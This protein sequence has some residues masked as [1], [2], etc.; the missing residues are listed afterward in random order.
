M[1]QSKKLT[2]GALLT[3]IYIVLLIMAVF[4]P[5]ISVLII[6]LLPTPFIFYTYK[7]GWKPALLVFVAALI[8][9]FLFAPVISMPL[10]VLVGA[11]GIMIG[12]SLHSGLTPYESW[13]RG[14]VGFIAGLLFVFIA[15]QFVLGVNWTEEIDILVDES[16]ETSTALL[17]Q[18]GL[19]QSEDQQE[20]VR[21]Q[22]N[23]MKNLLP[24]GFAMTAIF[25]AFI[26]QWIGYKVINRLE[27]KQLRFPPFRQFQLP[28]TLIWIYFSALIISLFDL[29]PSGAVYLALQNVLYLVILF[30]TLQG[31]SFVFFYAHQKKLSKAVPV[32]I[33]IASFI[34]PFLLYLVRI[35][36]IID[37]GFGLRKRMMDK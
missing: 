17:E 8:L 1:N 6:L 33:V 34:L 21:E 26:S 28:V 4:I 11:G 35:I 24:V 7:Y 16:M 19:D 5:I 2:D 15:S 25:L 14:T 37:I 13:A 32:I 9:S 18:A 36:G 22:M 20:L 27:N 3:T 30:L 29:D 31:F 10:T 23:M 12:Q